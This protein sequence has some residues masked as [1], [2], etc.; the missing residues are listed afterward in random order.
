MSLR[1]YEILLPI[2]YNDGAP[3]EEEKF[4]QTRRELV[5]A[6]GAF[7]TQP[8]P[9][10]G[11]WTHEGKTYEDRSL[12]FILDVEATPENRRFLANFKETLKA[13]FRQLDVW[14]ISYEID[15]H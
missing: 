14:M 8:E 11:W 4:A 13:R 5:S 2:R 7:T 3:V 12:R 9:M 1:R 15:I 10:Q 6:F